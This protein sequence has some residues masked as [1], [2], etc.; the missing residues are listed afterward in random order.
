MDLF[1]KAD[2]AAKNEAAKLDNLSADEARQ[3]I[4]RLSAEIN[5]HDMKYHGEDAPDIS[6]AD[7]DKLRQRLTQLENKYPQFFYDDSPNKKV[8]ASAK[9]GFKKIKHQQ[10]M[11]SLSNGFN[12][13]DIADFLSRIKRF[14]NLP[15]HAPIDI[16]A[17]PKIDGLSASLFYKAGKLEYAA[18]RGDGVEGEDITA[19]I[20]TLPTIPR[21]LSVDAHDIPDE[22]DIRGEIYMVRDDFILL[23]E[24]QQKD[25]KKIFANPRNAAAGSLRQLDPEVTRA[26]PLK[27]FAYAFGHCSSDWDKYNIHT[28]SD[29]REN[30][31]KWGFSVNEPTKLCHDIDALL[32]FYDHI[33]EGRHSLPFD[34]DGVVYKVNQLSLQQRLGQVSRAPRWAIAHKLPSETAITKLTDII[35]QVGRTGALTPVAILDPINVGGVMVGRASLHNEDE[36]ARKDIRINDNVVIKRAGDVIPKII[37]PLADKRTGGEVKFAFPTTCPHCGAA[38]VRRDGEA[39]RRCSG[40][41]NCPQQFSEYFSYFIG[42]EAFDIDG[43]GK[44]QIADF[45]KA[46][47]ITSPA[48]IFKL[49]KHED[50]IK[51]GEGWGELSFQNLINAIEDRRIISLERFIYALGIQ[52]VGQASAK[53]LARHF[54]TI[55]NLMQ[56]LHCQS[57]EDMGRVKQILTDI[58]QI[59]DSMADDI[60]RYF[61]T[62]L[63]IDMIRDLLGEI[64]VKSADIP[65]KTL[66]ISDKT[67]VF[68]GTLQK[69]GRLEAKAIAEKNGAKVSGAIS[70]KTDYLVAGDK[71]GSKAK[72]AESLG[73]TILSEDDFIALLDG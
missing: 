28:Q 55:E 73:V 33:N 61:N 24:R 4:I 68:T 38:A 64:Q 21:H 1:E 35:I 8:G 14:L 46:G 60:I 9:Q 54:V 41:F 39:V 2:E 65:N 36:I 62:P 26:R 27:F 67:I 15:D 20:L 32:Q 16:L 44:K 19:N 51:S 23:N 12:R 5:H 53:I 30:L 42:R 22:L 10:M 69:M 70:K 31:K 37:R 6:D 29:F 18:T 34:I 52:Q 66:K 13:D 11:L 56:C 58:D 71:A 63:Y 3:E 45:L 40:G 7:Y 49:K 48:D 50:A 17:E 72:K 57:D 47:F 59:G 25:G 43:F